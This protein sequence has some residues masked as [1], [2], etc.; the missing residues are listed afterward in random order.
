MLYNTININHFDFNQD[1][2]LYIKLYVLWEVMDWSTVFAKFFGVYLL[3]IVTIWLTRRQSLEKGI[4]EILSSNG[5]F[6]LSGAIQI[7][8]GL[9]ITILH[10]IW[11]ADWRGFITLLGYLSIFQ[12][13]LRLA[14]PDESRKFILKSIESYWIWIALAGFLGIFLTYHGF[15]TS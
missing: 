10:P 2:L 9:M 7:L 1:F 13:I 6:A 5:M 12:G 3:I 14:F 4:H 15:F 8:I 11:S